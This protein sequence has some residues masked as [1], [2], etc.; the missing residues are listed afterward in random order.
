[1]PQSVR[2]TGIVAAASA[3]VL[4]AGLVQGGERDGGATIAASIGAGLMHFQ[5]EEFDRQDRRLVKEAG[6]LPGLEGSLGVRQQAVSLAV[7]V[8]YYAGDVDY[9]GQ[10][11]S[12]V[13]IDSSTDQRIFEASINA[14][15]ELPLGLPPRVSVYAGGGYRHWDRDIDSVGAVS[16]L[17]ETYQ[18]WRAET[19]VKLQ[20]A[21]GA[22]A[23]ELEAGLTRTLNPQVDV[24]FGAAFDAVTLDLGERWGWRTAA[25][26]SHRVSPQLAAGLKV[27]YA[28]WDLGQSSV[29]T[30]T[31][32]G[33]TA[34]SVFQPRS[35]SRNYGVIL[36]LHRAW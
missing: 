23:W 5:F 22:N 26:W 12:G 8:G 33:V 34:G 3:L 15:C 11:S 32:N 18:W 36:S 2:L 19:G 1:M 27:F 25:S 13:P 14:A 30:L 7:D 35:E 10:T 16:G 6:W 4:V 24:D 28:S 21:R 20:L 9:D 17:D 31:S 29:E